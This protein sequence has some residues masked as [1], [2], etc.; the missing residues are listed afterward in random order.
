[1]LKA[2]DLLK[3][4]GATPLKPQATDSQPF[5]IEGKAG[6]VMLAGIRD[7]WTLCQRVSLGVRE[8]TRDRFLP[9]QNQ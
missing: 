1:M 2:S 8:A 6:V 5:R 3:A 9:S 7:E 4:F